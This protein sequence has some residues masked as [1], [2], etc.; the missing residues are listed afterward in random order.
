MHGE[1]AQLVALAA[2]GTAFLRGGGCAPELFP[3]HSTFRFV[4]AVRFAR[5]SR[6]L[7]LL[8]VERPPDSGTAS[9]LG[10]LRRRGAS[11]LELGRH[12][13]VPRK[14]ELPPH[15][16]AGFSNGLDVALVARDFSGSVE[17]WTGVWE[18][19]AP[20]H[21]EQRI[22]S[23]RYRGEA[24]DALTR[25]PTSLGSAAECLDRALHAAREFALEHSWREWANVFRI[26]AAELAAEEP[27]IRHHADMLPSSGYGLRAR[28]VLAA[29]SAGWVLGGMG[30]WNDLAARDKAR[31]TALTA[32]LHTALVDAA[33]VAANSFEVAIPTPSI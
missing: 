31:Y 18:V 7:G 16:D 12:P 13:G 21:P 32:E 2:H 27:T 9:W 17:L 11:A 3:G 30:S 25:C 6:L 10:D 23:V 22:W 5:V 8:P 14:R 24:A 33:V 26:A 4:R 29:V 15:M 20:K 28:Q 19:A 1:L